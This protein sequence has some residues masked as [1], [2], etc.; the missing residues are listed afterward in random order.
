M[1]LVT[2]ASTAG[3]PP[4]SPA[5]QQWGGGDG[6]AVRAFEVFRCASPFLP[7]LCI[8]LVSPTPPVNKKR[9][10]ETHHVPLD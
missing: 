10:E 3:G 5:G 2:I 7:L 6:G 4:H 1:A 8:Q 9:Q